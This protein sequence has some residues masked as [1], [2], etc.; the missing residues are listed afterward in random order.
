MVYGC[1]QYGPLGMA[2]GGINDTSINASSYQH[3]TGN[4]P[5]LPKFARLGGDK[6]WASDTDTADPEP[7]IQVDLG[8]SHIVTKLQIEGDFH[9]PYYQYWV[10]QVTVQYGMH[11]GR[12]KFFDDN[13]GE[14]K[15][16][17]LF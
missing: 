10:E 17:R 2:S 1:L 3:P 16:R 15:V 7:W 4:W 11:D 13:N 12:L 8:S 9:S 14:P 6:F 5:R